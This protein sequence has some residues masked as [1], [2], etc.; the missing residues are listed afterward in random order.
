MQVTGTEV[1]GYASHAQTEGVGVGPSVLMSKRPNGL[2]GE[3]CDRIK[4]SVW[5]CRTYDLIN[6]DHDDKYLEAI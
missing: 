6:I 3:K 4:L 1:R 5:L 2:F